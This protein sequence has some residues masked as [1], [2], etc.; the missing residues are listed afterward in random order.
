MKH[1][2]NHYVGLD[3]HQ[4]TTVATSRGESGAIVLKAT[5]PTEFIKTKGLPAQ[6]RKWVL[7]LD[8]DLADARLQKSK[9][10]PSAWTELYESRKATSEMR[11]HP[12][13]P[14]SSCDLN[15]RLTL[16][17]GPRF[18]PAHPEEMCYLC[19]RSKVLPMFPVVQRQ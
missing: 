19:S 12:E 9:K 15:Q 2:A 11:L 8:I 5:V 13:R 3:V 18:W 7:L 17:R 1:Q 16:P 4:A 10:V 6:K 14:I